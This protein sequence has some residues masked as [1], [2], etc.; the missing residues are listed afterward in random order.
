MSTIWIIMI[1]ALVISAIALPVLYISSRKQKSGLQKTY[2]ALGIMRAQSPL[3]DKPDFR[4]WC[5]SCVR[6]KS[7]FL[8][9]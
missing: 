4:L 7:I 1:G 3:W 2:S 8:H 5:Q 9:L 6:E